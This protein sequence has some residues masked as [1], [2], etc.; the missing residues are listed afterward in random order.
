MDVI[1]RL[2]EIGMTVVQVRRSDFP[3]WDGET[4]E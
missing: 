1:E 4:P 3:D 2:R